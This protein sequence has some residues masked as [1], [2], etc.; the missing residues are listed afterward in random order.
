MRLIAL[1]ALLVVSSAIAA[2]PPGASLEQQFTQTVRPFLAK[3]CIGCH[4]GDKPE[5]QLDLRTFQTMSSA[6]KDHPRW[7]MILERLNAD[8]MPPDSE[9]RP[10]AKDKAAVTAWIK[11]MRAQEARKNAGDPGVVLA[12]RLSNSEYN[13]TIRDL[14]GVDLKPTREFPI[15]PANPS[16]FDNSGESLTMSPALLNKYLQAA[17]EVGDHMVLHPDGFTFAPH[18]MLVE[19][20]RE[21]YAIQRIVEFYKSQPTDYADYFQAAWRYKHRVALGKPTATLASIAAEA[22]ISA[23][24][25]PMIWQLIEVTPLAA[26]S[27]VG[28]VAKLQ[29]MWRALPPPSAKKMAAVRSQAEAMRDYVV[30]IRSVTAMQ[31]AAPVVRGLS[32]TSQPLMNWKLFE[33]AK[34]RRKFDPKALRTPDDPP[35]VDPVLPRMPGLGQESAGRAALLMQKSRIGVED[36]VVPTAERAK[37]EAS[38]A[39]FANVFPDVFYISERGRFFPDDSEDKGR[40]LSAGYHNVM[41]Y[42]RDDTP[43]MELILDA[44]GVKELNRLW[45][46][47]D[48]IGDH[49]SRTWIQYYFNQS[50]EVA[51]MGRE[52]G[53]ARPS[54]KDVSATPVIFG[55]REAYLKRAEPSKNPIADQAI[56][57]HFEWVNN[58]LRRVEKMRTD[59][60]PLHLEALV[61]FAAKAYRRPISKAERDDLLAYYRKLRDSGALSHEEAMRDSIVTILMTPDFSYR[62]DMKPAGVATAAVRPMTNTEL[63]N[64]LSYFI[65]SSMPDQ[66]LMAHAN[67]G[68]LR[69]PAVLTAEIRRM[70]KDPKV[71]GLATEFAG[72][73]LEFRRFEN[74][75][76]VDRERFPVFNNDLRQAM[77]EEPVRFIEDVIRNNRSVFDF[78]YGNYTFVNPALAR[79]Y[80]MPEITGSKNTW[81]RVD[82]AD[83]YER[84][85]LLPMAAFLTQNSPGLRTSPVKR[86]YWIAKRVLGD[87]IP[88]PPPS[89]PEL[90]KDEGTSNLPVRDMLVQHRANP[91]CASCHARF[92]MFGLVLEGYG[93]VGELRSKDL[94]GRDVDTKTTFPG[95]RQGTGFAGVKAFIKDSKQNGY[96]DNLSRK[97]LSY[98][99]GRSLEF[100]DESLV[101]KM[102]SRLAASN[103]QFGTL[104]EVIA[105]SPQFLNKR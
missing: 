15:D 86:G 58:T 72:N 80:G 48:F 61:K 66:Q 104:V 36:L 22:K 31:F 64:R 55:L 88:P 26:K 39:R 59:A 50:G 13:Y 16:G 12:R 81:V 1:S 2:T 67:S 43:L 105:T 35:L 11:A 76:G 18:P 82:E 34:S 6:V 97:L 83:R 51:G 70:L 79:H 95:G 21:K 32:P 91:L 37:Y 33:F 78:L 10:P 93:P 62:I 44:K 102:Q 40:F 71:R 30:K 85:G 25:L 24:Y 73:W 52:S 57:D 20:D 5:A 4:G 3:H 101:L 77:F 45:D 56:K 98:A 84:G 87:V 96:V 90:P 38:F 46:E 7:A 14:T 65:W 27:E 100:S 47:F 89:V 99:L 8:E 54:D 53:S 28:P 103:Y 60:E 75:N 29:A 42:F 19:T 9:E 41:G 74:H 23:K 49:T 92:D 69:N 68:E 63:A 17:R 94:A